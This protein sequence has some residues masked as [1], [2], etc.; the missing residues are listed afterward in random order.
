MTKI[1]GVIAAGAAGTATAGLG[2]QRKRQQG[3]R[4]TDFQKV[5]EKACEQLEQKRKR[6]AAVGK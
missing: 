1:N 2:E 4:D 5:F 6:G 3:Q